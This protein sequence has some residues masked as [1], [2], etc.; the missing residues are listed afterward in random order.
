M[1]KQLIA[2]ALSAA[3][4]AGG[5]SVAA[6]AAPLT[7]DGTALE[8]SGSYLSNNTTYVPIRTVTEA[9]RP[10]AAV[11]WSDGQAVVSAWDLNLTARP[12]DPYIQANGR[13]LYVP[14]GVQV[15]SGRALVPV[16]TLGAALG[17]QVD[18]DAA[19]G[20]VSV[21]GGASVLTHADSYY[22]E[23]DLYWLSRI[24]SAESRGESLLG[25]IAVG[26]VVLNRAASADFPNTIYSVIFDSRWGGQFEPV[27]N[28]TI[29]DAPAPSSIVAAKLCLEG[30]N[31]VGD[32]LYFLAPALT[33]NHWAMNQ[34]TY[35]T[36]IG[37]HWFY[38]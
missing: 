22:N 35:V 4:L 3:L 14:D 10:D 5:Q 38:R 1:K 7:I 16:R 27:R 31:A 21:T 2:A 12:G 11:S 25:Q 15:R 37:C 30:A 32:S 9:L 36:T 13:C 19:T 6:A 28:G 33:S 34:R 23:D 24:I 26:N 18:W 17:A 29:Y 8:A 20:S